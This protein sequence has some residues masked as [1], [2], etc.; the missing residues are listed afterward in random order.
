[1]RDEY[2]GLAL[3]FVEVIEQFEELVRALEILACSGFVYDKHL[4]AEREHGRD[5]YALLFAH[6]QQERVLIRL[7]PKADQPQGVLDG[8]FNLLFGFL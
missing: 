4:R 6:G 1:M 7:L 3:F 8:L 2:D 5:G